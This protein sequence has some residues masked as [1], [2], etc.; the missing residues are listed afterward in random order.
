[1]LKH[2]LSDAEHI[3]VLFTLDTGRCVQAK[4]H[5]KARYPVKDVEMKHY[6]CQVDIAR[7]NTCVFCGVVGC[8][9]PH[10]VLTSSE[11]ED[12]M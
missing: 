6:R 4:L 1:M 7:I 5:E 12:Q 2:F 3:D 9:T 11:D 8:N 10:L